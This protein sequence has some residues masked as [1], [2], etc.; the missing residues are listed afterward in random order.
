M[1]AMELILLLRGLVIDASGV[2]TS[3][4]LVYKQK[5][6]STLKRALPFGIAQGIMPLSGYFGIALLPISLFA[7]DYIV[8]LVL[9]RAIGIKILADERTTNIIYAYCSNDNRNRNI[10]DVCWC[11]QNWRKARH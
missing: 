2:C 3:I 11:C 1:N 9:L 7:Y 10:C 6:A 4:G 5:L 8:T